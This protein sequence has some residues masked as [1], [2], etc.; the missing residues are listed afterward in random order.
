MNTESSAIP[1]SRPQSQVVAPAEIPAFRRFYWLVR[2]EFWE[3]RAIYVAPLAV[4]ALMLLASLIGMIHLPAKMRATMALNPMQQREI[5]SQPYDNVALL[6]MGTTFIVALFYSLDSLHSERRDRSILFWKSLPVSDLSTVLTKA[7]IPILILPLI[8]FTVTVV[9]QLLVL[10]VSSAVLLASGV[11]VTALWT[12]LPLFS[13]WLML[14]AHLV[15]GHGLWYAPFYGWLILVSAWARRAPVLWA[16]LPLLAI[17]F[18]E[19]IAFNTS[20]FV[21]MLTRRLVGGPGATATS[22]SMESMLH[23]DP[24]HF[25]TSPGLWVGLA[26]TAAFLAG[27]VH[28]RR[29]QGPI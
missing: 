4:A 14:I 29:S 11:S 9:T 2:R 17:G 18:I 15:G 10:L 7:S 25:L 20:H 19:K 13:M 23:L 16:V 6:L 27:A 5:I 8:T 24:V 1:E 22:S 21:D 28:L 3:S 12:N 26:L